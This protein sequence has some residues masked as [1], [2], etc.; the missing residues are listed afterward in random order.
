MASLNEVLLEHPASSRMPKDQKEWV[1]FIRVLS[2]NASTNA[3]VADMMEV[4][5]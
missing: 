3:E 1:D 4:Y 2:E 5:T